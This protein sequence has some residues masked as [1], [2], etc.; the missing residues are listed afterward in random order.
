MTSIHQA[1]HNL[2]IASNFLLWFLLPCSTMRM[3][4]TFSKLQSNRGLLSSSPA[5]AWAQAPDFKSPLSGWNTFLC[6]LKCG[7]LNQYVATGQSKGEKD[8]P[9]LFQ[10]KQQ[11]QAV[12]IM[13][14]VRAWMMMSM[15]VTMKAQTP[16]NLESHKVLG[17]VASP[18]KFLSSISRVL[19]L[20]RAAD[21]IYEL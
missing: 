18:S 13:N 7:L 1:G 14:Q 3:W 20:K 12:I 17:F 19:K 2:Y 5:Q 11:I 21:I 10:V 9:V 8:N 15:T 4:N 16:R 6:R